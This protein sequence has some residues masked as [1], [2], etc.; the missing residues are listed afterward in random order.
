MRLRRSPLLWALVLVS[1]LLLVCPAVVHAQ[2]KDANVSY[3]LNTTMDGADAGWAEADWADTDWDDAGWASVAKLN[4][5]A[6]GKQYI[7]GQG[8]Y[9][10]VDA[11]VDVLLAFANGSWEGF[12]ARGN[13]VNPHSLFCGCGVH[14]FI[15]CT[16]LTC[17]V[18]VLFRSSFWSA[19]L[20]VRSVV[21]V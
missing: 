1:G 3:A 10:A 11:P 9:A 6:D 8:G 5:T 13:E 19:A 21:A 16:C 14:A 18:A 2:G 12:D 20:F 17:Y 4:T 7:N 15:L